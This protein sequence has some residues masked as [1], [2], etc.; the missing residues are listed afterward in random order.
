MRQVLRV[1]DIADGADDVEVEDEEGM[2]ELLLDEDA[3]EVVG[4]DLED[5][6]SRGVHRPMVSAARQSIT[7]AIP[8]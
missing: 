1:V 7:S 4:D 5:R 2:A 3:D 8:Y 6:V